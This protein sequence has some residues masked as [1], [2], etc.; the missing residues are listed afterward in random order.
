MNQLET[1]KTPEELTAEEQQAFDYVRE[2]KGFYGH[3]ATYLLVMAGLFT[4]NFLT[5]PSYIWAGWSAL[6]WGIGVISHGVHVFSEF[7]VFGAAWE[8][9]Q[10]EKRLRRKL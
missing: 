1:Y 3:L 9:R 8:R 6:G 7:D 2:L 10:V 4:L 5:S